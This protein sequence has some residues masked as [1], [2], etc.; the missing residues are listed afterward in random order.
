MHPQRLDA[1]AS[2][3]AGVAQASHDMSHELARVDVVVDDDDPEGVRRGDYRGG[4]RVHSILAL[5][6]RRRGVQGMFLTSGIRSRA[7]PRRIGRATARVW[8]SCVARL[9][10]AADVPDLESGRC[11]PSRPGTTP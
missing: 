11:L 7:L 4:R 5:L 8:H 9:A 2:H 1:V 10:N 3:L 6:V